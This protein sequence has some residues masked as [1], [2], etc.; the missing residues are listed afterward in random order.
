MLKKLKQLITDGVLEE[1]ICS[2]LHMT[3]LAFRTGLTQ[4]GICHDF[5]RIPLTMQAEIRDK[6]DTPDWPRRKIAARYFI[7]LDQVLAII[8]D[9]IAEPQ[10]ILPRET[11]VKLINSGLTQAQLAM[12]YKTTPYHIAKILAG[13]D[14]GK[15]GLTPERYNEMIDMILDHVPVKEIAKEFNI[16][17]Q[18]IYRIRNKFITL[19]ERKEHVKVD[20]IVIQELSNKGFTQEEIAAKLNITQPTVH[21]H[22]RKT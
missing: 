19:P 12:L 20:P 8:Y 13:Q 3:H 18:I 10:A 1:V 14:I 6:V 21:R 15:H 17:I 16:S 11:I 9:Q 7:S 4:H 22:L 2:Q 5:T